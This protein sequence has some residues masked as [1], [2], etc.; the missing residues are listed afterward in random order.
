MHPSWHARTHPDRPALIMAASGKVLTY[1]QLEAASNRGANLFRSLGLRPG[2]AIALLFDNSPTFV[3]TCWAAQRAGLYFT[4]ISTRLTLEEAL[5]ILNDSGARV[6]IA[7]FDAGA[8]ATQ[9]AAARS[10]FASVQDFF[11]AGGTPLDGAD[12]WSA[13]AMKMSP[14]PIAG[15]P[16]GQPMIYSS[17]TTGRPKGVKRPLTGAPD[18][19]EHPFVPLNRR[20]YGYA[21]DMIYL[22]PAPFYHAAPLVSSMIVHRV[23]GTV[24]LM[25]HFTP[26]DALEAIERYHVTH[27]QMV[28][29]MFVRLLKMS[30]E[31][32]RG[33]DVSSLR[34]VMHA[35]APC[36][37][38]IKRQMIDWLGPILY[39]YYAGTEANGMT[40]LNSEEWLRKP[41]SVGRA[42]L[43]TLHICDDEGRELAAGEQGSVYFEGGFDFHY[44]NDEAKTAAARNPV[45]PSWSTLG[46]VGYV[47]E[48]GYLFLTDRKA[49]MIISGGVNIYPQETENVLITH[50]QVADV[51]VIG[52][53]NDEFGEEVKAVVQP[54][55]WE[56]ATPSFAQELIAYCRARLSPIKCPRSVDFER[57][58]PRHDTGKLYKRL[59]RDRYWV[60]RTS[61]IV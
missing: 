8:L 9:L 54:E 17:G 20:L 50:P 26:E 25:E 5:Y 15:E 27:A 12:D 21:E 30:E 31:K 38:P 61:R 34:V 60:G 51:S 19:A 29:T 36:P 16:A 48:D 57:E 40:Y 52:V 44:H 53:P 43:G 55:R 58:L 6:L 47:D 32:R 4:P 42:V 13:A 41:G 33:Y 7:S 59:L 35:A 23:G 24:V 49:F 46:D 39:E 22:S 14:L 18:D 28:P 1:A 10:R 11:C 56:D 3:E 2:D 45:H 37:V